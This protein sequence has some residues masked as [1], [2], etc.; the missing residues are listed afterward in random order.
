M[1]KNFI[2]VLLFLSFSFLLPLPANGEEW[3]Q[4]MEKKIDKL[5]QDNKRLKDRVEELE[6]EQEDSNSEEK[7][8]MKISGYADFE[9]R[10]SDLS[11]E[12]DSFKP[13]HFS[14]FFSKDVQPKW[15]LFSELEFEDAPLVEADSANDKATPTTQ[16]K[17][18]AEQMY[19]EYRPS[20]D[21]DI[22]FGRFLTPAGIWSVYHYY[23]YVPTQSRPLHIRKIF[24]QVSDGIKLRKSFSFKEDIIDA[25]VYV[26][27]GSGNPG[28]RDK[29]GN[30][31]VGFKLNYASDFMSG[32]QFGT[33]YYNEEDNSSIKKVS[34]GLHFQLNLFDF[35]VQS[36]YAT[37]NNA[38]ETGSDYNDTGYYLQ[39]MYDIDKW[40]IAGRYDWYNSN[41]SASGNKQ[42]TY[43]TAINYHFATNVVAKAE[44]N[45][46]NFDSTTKEDFNQLILAIVVG[47]GD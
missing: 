20:V 21:L 1:F 23:P 39:V 36:E 6:I 11:T 44:Y 27:N 32:L 15:N 43:T 42:T 40:T 46:N 31:A 41:D 9:Y 7:Q 30:K 38:P 3:F 4:R 14:L 8:G 33:S 47:I 24:P 34:T 17:I 22:S 2:L 37:R 25:R 19:I 26:S 12:H 45:I 29:N 5:E 18:F 35:E 10:S 13:R 16:G 28:K